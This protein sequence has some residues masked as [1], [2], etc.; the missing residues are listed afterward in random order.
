MNLRILKTAR[1]LGMRSAAAAAGLAWMLVATTAR[2][3]SG[4][5]PVEFVE[6]PVEVASTDGGVD[7]VDGG[8]GGAEVGSDGPTTDSGSDMAAATDARDMGAPTADMGTTTDVPR[9]TPRDTAS[10]PTDSDGDC[11]C[12]VGGSGRRGAGA[13][14]VLGAALGVGL[15]LRRSRRRS[16]RS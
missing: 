10:Q 15:V 2:G 4:N 8:D 5:P 12:R 14:P 16:G 7:G 9:D 13:L 11:G 6:T 1:W 3:E